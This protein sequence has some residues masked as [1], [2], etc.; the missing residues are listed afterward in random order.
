MSAIITLRQREAVHIL[1]DGAGYDSEGTVRAVMSKAF[2]IPHLAAVIAT[3]GSAVALPLIGTR[4]SALFSS[5]DDLVSGIEAELPKIVE[6]SETFFALSGAASTELAVIGWSDQNNSGMAFTIQTGDV[7]DTRPEYAD[8]EQPESFKL[9]ERP[10]AFALPAPSAEIMRVAAHGF[11]DADIEKLVPAVDLLHIMEMQRQS[12]V[13]YN[14]L[15]IYVVGGLALL[16]TV[17]RGGT[18]TQRV[19]H[20]WP[21]DRIGEDIR[22]EPIDDWKQWRTDLIVKN[23]GGSLVGMSRLKREMFERKARKG[24][25]RAA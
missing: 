19:I 4:L 2:A 23:A 17:T 13:E 15:D 1:C 22:P 21:E 10:D 8:L 7:S 14:G 16:S 18:I 11:L 20:R 3:R 5:F 12:L 25:L 24:T 9:V 6:D